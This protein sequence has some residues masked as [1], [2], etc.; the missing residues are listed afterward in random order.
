MDAFSPPPYLSSHVIVQAAVSVVAA[1]E[2]TVIAVSVAVVSFVVV[3]VYHVVHDF[4]TLGASSCFCCG[5][6]SFG[7]PFEG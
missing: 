1:V 3:V 7:R 2:S 6:S 5:R 4:L